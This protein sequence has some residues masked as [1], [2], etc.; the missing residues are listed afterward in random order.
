M[1]PTFDDLMK[2]DITEVFLQD[3][4]QSVR[5]TDNAGISKEF[6]VQFFRNEGDG[7]D[8]VYNRVWCDVKDVPNLSTKDTFTIND[9]KYGVLSFEYDEHKLSVNIYINE[10]V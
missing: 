3:L 5:Y 7:L 1:L 6:R 9:I 8:T 2:A 4:T 10:I